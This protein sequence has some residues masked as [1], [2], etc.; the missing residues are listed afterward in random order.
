MAEPVQPVV[1]RPQGCKLRLSGDR[2][3]ELAGDGII[4]YNVV[5]A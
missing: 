3:M 2:E 1:D 4:S 5:S